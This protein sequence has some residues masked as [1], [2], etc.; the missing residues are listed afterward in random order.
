MKKNV[1][2]PMYWTSLLGTHAFST[3]QGLSFERVCMAHIPQIKRK[4]KIE[5]I[6]TEYYSWRSTSEEKAQVD[7][8]LER[9]D[10]IVNV[11]EIKYSADYYNMSKAEYEKFQ[12][13]ISLF[14]SLT[15]CKFGV[16]P[17]LVTTQLAAKGKYNSAIPVVI[18][19]DDLFE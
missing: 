8:V 3:W 11:C 5:G 6:Y 2:D 18:T 14:R 1:T 9:A 12:R 10:R 19:L 16:M 7:L 15:N 4:L 13:S 17:T